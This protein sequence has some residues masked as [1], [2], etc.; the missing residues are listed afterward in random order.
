MDVSGFNLIKPIAIDVCMHTREERRIELIMTRR[1]IIL[2]SSQSTLE[3][4]E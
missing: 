3:A 4:D 1:V 2:V